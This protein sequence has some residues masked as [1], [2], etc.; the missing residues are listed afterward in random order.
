MLIKSP[1][2]F[3]Y[4]V[5]KHIDAIKLD[6][7]PPDNT[8]TLDGAITLVNIDEVNVLHIDNNSVKISFVSKSCEVAHFRIYHDEVLVVDESAN[9]ITKK[10]DE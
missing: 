6:L 4:Q 5:L 1:T 2:V 7:S 8:I 3:S 9:H 10:L